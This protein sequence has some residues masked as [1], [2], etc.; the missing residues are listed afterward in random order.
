MRQTRIMPIAG[1]AAVGVAAFVLTPGQSAPRAASFAVAAGRVPALREAEPVARLVAARP[2]ARRS[3]ALERRVRP[4]I[5]RA[6]RAGSLRAV[7]GSTVPRLTALGALRAGG[8]RLGATALLSLPTP[9]RDVRATLPGYVPA[10]SGY[11]PQSVQLTATVLRDLLV[12]I[13]L[14]RGRVIAVQPGPR[15]QTAR[16]QPQHSP[17]PW[18]ARDED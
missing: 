13:D 10:G 15:S 6:R 9:R 14:Q 7:L 5:D 3:G 11:R 17:A 18:T 8:H 1:L 2:A 16:W 4:I 12:D